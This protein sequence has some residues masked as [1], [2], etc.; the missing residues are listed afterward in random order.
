MSELKSK[1]YLDALN[2]KNQKKRAEDAL[3]YIQEQRNEFFDDGEDFD[4]LVEI[5]Y[6]YTDE[7]ISK[8]NYEELVEI[9]NKMESAGFTLNA[10]D[11]LEISE[12]EYLLDMISYLKNMV[13]TETKLGELI[14]TFDDELMKVNDELEEIMKDY[15]NSIVHLMREEIVSNPKFKESKLGDLYENIMKSFDSSFDLQPVLNVAK[16]LNTSNTVEDYKR[17]RDNVYK[18]YERVLRTLNVK[19]DIRQFK[20]IQEVV[21]NKRYDGYEDF[22]LFIFAKYIAKRGQSVDFSKKID[23]VFASQLCTNLYLLAS[24]VDDNVIQ[25]KFKDACKELLELYLG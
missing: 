4:A 22:L 13:E 11:G 7:E 20:N 17:N 23:G 8:M 18:Q 1:M 24:D 15:S 5:M 2:V 25:G 19:H 21:T 3:D 10:P 12:Q 14:N 9:K 16:E 6:E